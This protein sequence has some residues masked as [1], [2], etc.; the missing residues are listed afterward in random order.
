MILL[1]ETTEW[2]VPTPNHI[3]ILET[4]TSMKMVGY[5]PV[6]VGKREPFFF[7]EPISLDRRNRTFQQLDLKLLAKGT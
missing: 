6:G 3:Y 5:I 1:Q 4:R 7:K 2:K